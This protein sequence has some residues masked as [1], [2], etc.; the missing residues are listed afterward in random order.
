MSSLYCYYK[1]KVCLVGKDHQDF[2]GGKLLFHY[3]VLAADE[4]GRSYKTKQVLL[5]LVQTVDNTIAVLYMYLSN[6]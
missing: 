2:D 4:K 1:C 3:C 5:R 6:L